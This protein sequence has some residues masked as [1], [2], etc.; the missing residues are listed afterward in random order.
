MLKA[1]FLKLWAEIVLRLE[2]IKHLQLA[3]SLAPRLRMENYYLD[4]FI[5]VRKQLITS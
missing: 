4:V 1:A 3:S 2:S 5:L